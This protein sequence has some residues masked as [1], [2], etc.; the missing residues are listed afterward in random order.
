LF[1]GLVRNHRHCS[2]SREQRRQG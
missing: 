1:K 2:T